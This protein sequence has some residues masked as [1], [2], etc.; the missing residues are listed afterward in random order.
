MQTK[1]FQPNE[2]WKSTKWE[3]TEETQLETKKKFELLDKREVR[4]EEGNIY[5][6]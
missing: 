2:D 4:D 5:H 3:E 1:I 6:H